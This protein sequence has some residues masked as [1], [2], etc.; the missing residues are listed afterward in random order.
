MEAWTRQAAS[1][2][3]FSLDSSGAAKVDYG[4]VSN[5]V[6]FD[7]GSRLNVDEDW[8]C[9][10]VRCVSV[11]EIQ[12]RECIEEQEL[13]GLGR[14]CGQLWESNEVVWGTKPQAGCSFSCSW[15]ARSIQPQSM[16][17]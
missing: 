4:A 3:G 8:G 13:R 1:W 16:N 15:L 12:G 9:F 2:R 5:T 10:A 14:V 7:L 17:A 6:G 11:V